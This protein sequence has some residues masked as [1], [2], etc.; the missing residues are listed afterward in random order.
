MNFKSLALA[1]LVAIST[2]GGVTLEAQA[3]GGGGDG[4]YA[5]SAVTAMDDALSGG[6]TLKQAWTW[7][8][9]DGYAVDTTRCWTVVKGYAW[10]YQSIKRAFASTVFN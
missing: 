5:P 6:A 3:Y 2:I 7:A 10:K 1:S 4:C 8:I 9:D